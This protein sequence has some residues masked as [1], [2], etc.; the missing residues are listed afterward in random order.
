MKVF[1]SWSGGLSLEIAK[2]FHKW[3][4]AVLQSVRPYFTPEDIRK[5]TKWSSEIEHHLNDSKVGIFCVT[6]S[7]LLSQWM[8][9]EAGAISNHIEKSNVCPILFDMKVT[10]LT[11]PFT[12]FQASLFE[13]SEIFKLIK[14]INNACSDSELND[15]VLADVFDKWWPDLDEV[16]QKILK[17]H[18][19]DNDSVL[20]SDR[21]LI[22]EILELTRVTTHRALNPAGKV[23]MIRPMKD[24][25]YNEAVSD[26]ID[27]F[28]LVFD[29]DW[30][31]TLDNLS[32]DAVHCFIE[33]EGTFIHPGV[34]DE[35][36]NWGNRGSLL[37]AYRYLDELMKE[38][39]LPRRT[40]EE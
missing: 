20:R 36:N 27:H 35:S 32:P 13:K 22:E 7:N 38:L 6:R 11:G 21:E 39:G 29:N 25:A 24:R 12:Q 16:V 5:G 37:N 1:I 26:F 18:I 14:T 4:P 28:E 19:V 9:F 33:K 3:L 17:N 23:Q 34:D 30:E 10:D 15:E 31:Y 8:M 40:F 2:A